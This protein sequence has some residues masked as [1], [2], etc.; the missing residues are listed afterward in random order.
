[1]K[2]SVA[3]KRKKEARKRWVV[4]GKKK[5]RE[6]HGQTRYPYLKRKREHAEGTPQKKSVH[7]HPADRRRKC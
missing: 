1:M 2:L 3:V 6:Q 7:A 5:E 4:R